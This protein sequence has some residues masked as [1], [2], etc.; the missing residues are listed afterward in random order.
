MRI[1]PRYVTCLY[2]PLKY[3]NFLVDKQLS[4]MLI[5]TSY[6]LLAVIGWYVSISIL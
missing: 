4:S 5:N 6:G 1:F 3:K 2:G